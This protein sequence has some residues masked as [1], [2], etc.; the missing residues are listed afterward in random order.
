MA[1]A[2][3]RYLGNTLTLKL[4]PGLVSNSENLMSAWIS[5]K[6]MMEQW[7]NKG[8]EELFPGL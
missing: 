7:E 8:A 2:H 6:K 4:L 5:G 1:I 3:K